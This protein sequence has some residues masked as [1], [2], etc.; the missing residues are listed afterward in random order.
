MNPNV[1]RRGDNTGVVL[2][3]DFLTELLT[4]ES[5]RGEWMATVDP[6]LSTPFLEAVV[7]IGEL[8]NESGWEMEMLLD[9]LRCGNRTETELRELRPAHFEEC[10]AF[11]R[12][13]RA[14]ARSAPKDSGIKCHLISAASK[15]YADTD[16]YTRPKEWTKESEAE[17]TAR[18]RANLKACKAG[19]QSPLSTNDPTTPAVL[20]GIGEVDTAFLAA[21]LAMPGGVGD[22]ARDLNA[23][24]P[25]GDEPLPHISPVTLD[26]LLRYSNSSEACEMSVAHAL[27]LLRHA[28][29]CDRCQSDYRSRATT[30]GVNPEV[31][32]L[33]RYQP[34]HE[35]VP[36]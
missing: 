14:L 7:L 10:S 19:L 16:R 17:A 22:R 30:L 20:I 28:N 32:S 6:E 4:N 35:H 26:A 24:N 13:V 3:I 1:P 36:S 12:W 31:P 21:R 34:P 15:L 8:R 5:A 9:E 2:G 18:R 33:L 23:A 27:S 25:F 29:G 11:L